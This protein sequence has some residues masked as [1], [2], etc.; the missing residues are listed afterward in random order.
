M[1]QLTLNGEF[2]F[3]NKSVN[4]NLNLYLFKE[5]GSFIVYCPALDM[6]AYGDSEEHAKKSFVDVFEISVKY[7]LNKNTMRD[8]LIHHGWQVKSMKQRR[9]KAPS[10]DKMLNSNKIFREILENKEY[11]TYKEKLGIPQFA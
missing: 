5:D 6:S 9:I 8:D 2:E 3:K 10:F 4:V 7:M 11:T 1:A